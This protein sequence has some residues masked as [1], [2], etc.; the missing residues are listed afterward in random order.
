MRT[1]E[2][3]R[4]TAREHLAGLGDRWAHVQAVGRLAEELL[5]AGLV[6][7]EVVCAAWLHDVGYSSTSAA[8]GFHPVDGARVLMNDGWSDEVVGLVAHHTGASEEAAERGLSDDLGAL[9][10]PSPELLDAITLIDLSVGPDG[11]L[12]RP[13]ERVAEILD[14]YAAGDPVHAAVTRSRDRLLASAERAR[15]FLELSDDWPLVAGQG[16]GDAESH[17]GVEF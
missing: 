8:T 11:S 4:V 15:N 13:R 1:L 14:R 6:G 16:V 9:P 12:T 2:D 3:A 7:E 10:M 5:D 17:R